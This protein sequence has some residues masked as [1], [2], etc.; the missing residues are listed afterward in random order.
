MTEFNLETALGSI[1]PPPNA[2]AIDAA[3]QQDAR[4]TSVEEAQEQEIDVGE[5]GEAWYN[6]SNP[7]NMPTVVCLW[8][9]TGWKVDVRDHPDHP[10]T[11][12]QRNLLF[13]SIR[14]SIRRQRGQAN[15]SSYIERR[16]VELQ[17]QAEVNKALE[18]S[19]RA[20]LLNPVLQK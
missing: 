5:A 1:V 16:K 12:H 10:L 11:N 18:E 4:P 15:F 2:A 8:T 3:I 7:E 14:I 13:R 6:V 17:K 9:P 19:A 20:G